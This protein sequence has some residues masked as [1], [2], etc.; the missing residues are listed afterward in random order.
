MANR[1][2][3]KV[4]F[5]TGKRPSGDDFAQLIDKSVNIQDDKATDAEAVVSSNNEK[6]MTPH[7]SRVMVN[8]LL[9][10][11][12]PSINGSGSDDD[13]WSGNKT[14]KK[15]REVLLTGLSLS[16][17]TVIT[18]ADQF[19]QAFGKLQA[20]ISAIKSN[21]RL[22]TEFIVSTNHSLSSSSALQKLFNS[23]GNG[24]YALNTGK[25]YKFSCNFALSG[26]SST[27]GDFSFGFLGDAAITLRYDAI[28]IKSASLGQAE[29]VSSTVKT[30]TSL[31]TANINTSGKSRITGIINCNTGGTLIPAVALGVANAANVEANS[32]FEIE[33]IGDASSTFNGAWS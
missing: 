8:P 33:E 17:T 4:L 22:R 5:S 25:K 30:A 12:E 31:V 27:S 24:S 19:I 11:K 29:F 10:T 13:Y 32:Y 20:Q 3:L 9:A 6:F 2:D 18:A 26:L 16:S 14:F 1:D 23:P 21:Y 28:S 7:T 15:V